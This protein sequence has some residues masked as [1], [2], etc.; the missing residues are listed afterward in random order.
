MA[1]TNGADGVE[2]DVILTKD[3]KLVCFHDVNA[4]VGIMCQL[5]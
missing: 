1:A 4:K 5:P 2:C 3:K